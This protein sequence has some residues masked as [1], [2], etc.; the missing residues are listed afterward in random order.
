MQSG[1][2]DGFTLIELM[3]VVAII[4]IL[5]AVA[6]PAYQDYA[7]RGKLAE[8]KAA[9]SDGRVKMEQSFQDSKTY[10]VNGVANVCPPTIPGSTE[11]FDIACNTAANTYTITATGKAGTNVSAFSY[12]I[13]E[14]NTRTSATPWGNSATCWVIKKGGVC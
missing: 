7:I 14:L 1:R 3:V 4:G 10:V 8:M 6:F 13:N 9:L 12:T 11:S 5:V 2:Q